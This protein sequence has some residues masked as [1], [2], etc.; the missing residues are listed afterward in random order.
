MADT[1]FRAAPPTLRLRARGTADRSRSAGHHARWAAAAAGGGVAAHLAMVASGGLMAWA[2]VVMA[3]ACA[4]CA[5]SMWRAPSLRSA[6]ILV[7]MSLGMALLHGALLLGVTPGMAQAGMAHAGMAHAGMGQAGMAHSGSG[8]AGTAPAQTAVP[9]ASPGPSSSAVGP[10]SSDPAD[11]ELSM[12]AVVG[13]DFAAAM[14]AASWIR[15]SSSLATTRVQ[16]QG[17]GASLRPRRRGRREPC[18]TS[19][20]RSRAVPSL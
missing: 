18:S 13:A 3:A 14:L 10:G 7:G 20:C 17:R 1:A 5:W 8:H 9:S 11:G 12:L 15:R 4:P 2:A 16:G 6:R 19:S